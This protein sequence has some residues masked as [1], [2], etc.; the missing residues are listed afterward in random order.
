[1]TKPNKTAKTKK[2]VNKSESEKQQKVESKPQKVEN[3]QRN[4]GNEQ[5][6]SD[7]F[8]P[9]DGEIIPFPHFRKY[10]KTNHPALIIG[11]SVNE[12]KKEEFV[13]RKVTHSERDGRHLNEKVVPNPNTKDSTPM[14]ISKRP[15]RDEKKFFSKW[16]YRWKYP[17]E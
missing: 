15:R 6:Q 12:K 2:N 11:E 3:K 13:Y 5:Q 17:K 14:Y 8:Y 16:I 9:E 1:M 4:K 7:T 10:F